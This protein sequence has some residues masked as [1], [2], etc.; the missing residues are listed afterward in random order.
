MAIVSAAHLEVGA[1]YHSHGIPTLHLHSRTEGD[2][3]LVKQHPWTMGVHE[4]WE[5]VPE[6]GA[7]P[8]APL[9]AAHGELQSLMAQLASTA[10]IDLTLRTSC[11]LQEAQQLDVACLAAL[12][13]T[14]EW[15]DVLVEAQCHLTHPA[16]R[17]SVLVA[18]LVLHMIPKPNLMEARM[19]MPIQAHS[20][21]HHP[22]LQR[23]QFKLV[24]GLSTVRHLA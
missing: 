15:L 24:E 22:S 5:E 7:R 8:V 1:Q 23:L 21:V 3:E 18:W 11:H 9:A 17:A 13:E 2:E 20:V 10:L 4:L 14:V 6:W 12:R 16:E 19:R